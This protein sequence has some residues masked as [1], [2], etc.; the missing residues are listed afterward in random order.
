MHIHHNPIGKHSHEHTNVNKDEFLALIQYMV[1]HNASHANELAELAVKL[2]EAGNH[3][4]YHKVMDAVQCF[5]RGNQFLVEAR[6]G[7]SE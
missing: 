3:E 2:D 4:A 7:L 5:Y 1:G 6:L